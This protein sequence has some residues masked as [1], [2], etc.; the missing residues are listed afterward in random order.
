LPHSQNKWHDALRTRKVTVDEVVKPKNADEVADVV[1]KAADHGRKVRCD[2]AGHSFSDV[3]VP[4]DVLVDPS[5]MTEIHRAGPTRVRVDT[6][7]RIRDLDPWL[8]HQGLAMPNLGSYDHQTLPGA[9]N[10][11]THGSGITLSGLPDLVR[12][13]DLVDSA[14][15]QRRLTAADGD[16]FLAATCGLGAVGLVTALELEVIPAYDLE[17]S[18]ELWTWDE[19][20][21]KLLDGTLLREAR[22]VEVLISPYRYT[23][24]KGRYKGENILPVNVLKKSLTAAGRRGGHRPLLPALALLFGDI[25]ASVVLSKVRN[26]PEELAELHYEACS[27]SVEKGY[28]DRSDKV[29]LQDVSAVPATSVEIGVPLERTVEAVEAVLAYAHHFK[30][31][32][33]YHTSPLNLRFVKATTNSLIAM[34]AYRDTTMIEIPQLLKTP[35]MDQMYAAYERMLITEFAGRPHWGKVHQLV[36]SQ[37]P[38]EAVHP[39]AGRWKAAY[40]ELNAKG[41]FSN[42]LTKRLG[43][44]P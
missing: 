1:K 41:T 26:H 12:S 31:S 33:W 17:E 21:P 24:K 35:G 19:I 32:G 28:V 5:R 42:P 20:K 7:V 10:T 2:A 14:G 9:C 3:A 27:T 43:L 11:G 6:G 22:H 25:S 15:G 8:A 44:D 38:L 40:A 16:L 4:V 13:I 39:L 18:A 23:P 29:L 34:Y 37:F 36:G 30:A